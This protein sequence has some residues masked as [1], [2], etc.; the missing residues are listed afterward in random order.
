[1]NSLPPPKVVLSGYLV[2]VYPERKLSASYSVQP[3]IISYSSYSKVTQNRK[4]MATSRAIETLKLLRAGDFISCQ[5]ELKGK[6]SK[7]NNTGDSIVMNMDE[8]FTIEK[9]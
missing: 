5:V 1:M 3:F 8:V 9:V 2:E 6:F 4:L 7:P